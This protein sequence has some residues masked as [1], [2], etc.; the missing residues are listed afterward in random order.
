MT[1]RRNIDFKTVDNIVDKLLN[2]KHICAVVKFIPTNEYAA[3]R[4]GKIGVSRLPFQGQKPDSVDKVLKG[5]VGIE[6]YAKNDR[7]GYS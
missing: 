3:K 2:V 5:S 4:Q 1:Y 7:F 6:S